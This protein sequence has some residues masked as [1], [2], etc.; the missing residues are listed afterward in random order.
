MSLDAVK[1]TGTKNKQD[2]DEVSIEPR[3]T[4]LSEIYVDTKGWVLL[5]WFIF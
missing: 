4:D 5:C 2:G 1:P 3:L